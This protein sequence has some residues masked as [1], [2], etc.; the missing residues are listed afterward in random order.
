MA[1]GGGTPQALATL[2]AVRNEHAH[3]GPEFLP[4]GNHFISLLRR[5]IAANPPASI[6]DRSSRRTTVCCSPP[7]P[8]QS[9][10]PA[11]RLRGIYCLSATAALWASHSTPLSLQLRVTRAL[12]LRKSTQSRAFLWPRLRFPLMERW[13]IKAR[14][15]PHAALW[16]LNAI[17]GSAFQLTHMARGS[18]AQPVMVA[19][20]FANR[21]CKR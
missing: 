14:A 5:L 17:D 18:S 20:R 12:W 2:N 16:V 9:I 15:S 13:S 11:G 6:L 19:R 8:M 21:I 7:K 3:P 10:P 4:G 1:A